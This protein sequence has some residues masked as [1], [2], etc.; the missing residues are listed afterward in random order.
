MKLQEF[1]RWC[2]ARYGKDIFGMVDWPAEE[3]DAW[4]EEKTKEYNKECKKERKT[5]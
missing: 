5:K 1:A 2:K 3:Y 4:I